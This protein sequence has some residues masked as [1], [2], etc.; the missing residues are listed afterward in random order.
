MLSLAKMWEML[1]LDY[2]LCLGSLPFQVLEDLRNQ[3]PRK[4]LLQSG[5]EVPLSGSHTTI[6]IL[7]TYLYIS[8]KG[9]IVSEGWK[10]LYRVLMVSMWPLML[11]KKK[12]FIC[13]LN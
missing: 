8:S 1:E 5:L 4:L 13:Y 11:N 12:F 7:I 10:R 9:N 2:R 3:A 6:F